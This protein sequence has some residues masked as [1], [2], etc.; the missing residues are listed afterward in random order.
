MSIFFVSLETPYENDSNTPV[1]DRSKSFTIRI[2]IFT[3]FTALLRGIRPHD[4]SYTVRS[5][6]E[7]GVQK[8]FESAGKHFRIGLGIQLRNFC[9]CG[10]LNNCMGH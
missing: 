9:G 6:V 5:S 4:A 2:F 7:D 1:S 3:T 10:L 8:V